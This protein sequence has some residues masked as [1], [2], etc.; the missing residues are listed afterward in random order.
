VDPSSALFF[1]YPKNYF[2]NSL[3]ERFRPSDVI[4]DVV[5]DHRAWPGLSEQEKKQ[6]TNHY[7]QTLAQADLVLTNCQPVM[8][9]MEAL[10]ATVKVIQNGCEPSPKINAPDHDARFDEL[11]SW[12]GPIAGFVGNLEKKID[13]DLLDKLAIELPDTLFV[14]VGSTHANPA[15]R[16]LSAHPNVLMP[17]V[18]SYEN[19]PAWIAEFT[20]GLIPHKRNALTES[21]NPLKLYVY[22]AQGLPVVSTSVS[23]LAEDYDGLHIANS[24]GEFVEQVK[25]ICAQPKM[26]YSLAYAER[27]SWQSRLSECIDAFMLP[28]L[29]S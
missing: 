26:R 15:V 19:V 8:R 24:V 4:V 2:I 17:G 12:Q 9:S 11:K 5:D 20:V 6:L 13:I 21:M 29:V 10:G 28:R 23:N 27:N 18:V 25:M 7:T 14:L 1:L 22:A 3:L 16:S